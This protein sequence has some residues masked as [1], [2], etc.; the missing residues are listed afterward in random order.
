[1]RG[2]QGVPGSGANGATLSRLE[3]ALIDAK[4]TLEVQFKRIAQLQA[5]LD[6]LR[7]QLRRQSGPA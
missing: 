3:A 2:P 5:Q 7:A 4:D 1:M 6:E